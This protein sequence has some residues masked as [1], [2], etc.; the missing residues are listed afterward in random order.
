MSALLP[1]GTDSGTTTHLRKL[2]DKVQGSH[3][4]DSGATH[5]SSRNVDNRER[6]CSA[7]SG[8]GGGETTQAAVQPTSAT[9]EIESKPPLGCNQST[10]STST[11]TMVSLVFES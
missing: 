8:N 7:L 4:R 1:V 2:D 6:V 10:R 11:G 5:G 3:D 9:C